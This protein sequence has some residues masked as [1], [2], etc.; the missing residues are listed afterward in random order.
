M[1]YI[2]LSSTS[3]KIK[4][5]IDGLDTK[6]SRS[7]RTFEL[8]LSET[9]NGSMIDSIN[10]SIPAKIASIGSFDFTGLDPDTKYYVRG[11]LFYTTG[12]GVSTRAYLD[13]V[14]IWTESDSGSGGGGGGG[15]LEPDEN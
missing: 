5:V 14:S 7:D 9:S 1:A 3:S 2:T 6:Y 13:E 11:F 10:G 4:A 12:D 8:Y 15:I